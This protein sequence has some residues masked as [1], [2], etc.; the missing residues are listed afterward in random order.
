MWNDLDAFFNAI[1]GV[2]MLEDTAHGLLLWMVSTL[3]THKERT[4]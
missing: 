2:P 1:I 3:H 4:R